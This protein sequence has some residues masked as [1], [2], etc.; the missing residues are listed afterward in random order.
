MVQVKSQGDTI[1]KIVGAATTDRAGNFS[2]P[3][4]PGAFT[5]A[6]ALISATPN[7]PAT[8]QVTNQTIADDFLYLLLKDVGCL[9]AG[10]N[11]DCDCDT[12]KRASRLPDQMDLIESDEYTQ[13]IGG[14]CINLS[15]PN[16]TLNEFNYQAIVRTSDPDVANYTLKKVDYRK[17]G[18]DPVL[19]SDISRDVKTVD[20]GIFNLFLYTEFSVA[21][22]NSILN[23]LTA[24]QNISASATPDIIDAALRNLDTIVTLVNAR[25]IQDTT[26]N[27]VALPPVPPKPGNGQSHTSQTSNQ[28]QPPVKTNSREPSEEGS[29]QKPSGS[30]TQKKPS[31]ASPY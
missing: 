26:T 17:E 24:L 7:S 22:R 6:Q 5:E 12:P 30:N 25:L 23:Q 20:T 27:P 11:E 2:M 4:P 15:T 3:Y 21:D 18:I 29:Q 9:D 8:I 31:N 14:S 16:R 10:C 13:D 19:F 28:Q 1:W